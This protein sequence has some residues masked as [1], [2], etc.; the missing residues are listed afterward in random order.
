M[1]A[2]AAG[3]LGVVI[4]VPG[5]LAAQLHQWRASFGEPASGLVPPHV[6]ILTHG[7]AGDDD[8]AMTAVAAVA[9]RVEPF[10]VV[11]RGAG[12]FLPRSPVVYLRLTAGARECVELHEG[13][14][15]A[16]IGS[17]AVFPYH[18]HVTLAQG[19]DQ[20]ALDEALIRFAGFAATFPARALGVFRAG[21]TAWEQV[22]E[23]PLGG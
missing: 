5:P 17:A 12:S 4:T 18:P 7:L 22:G 19:V 14:L 11:L 21:E 16:G 15:A 8:P 13:I 6:T 20:Q 2:P 1:A 10:T 3:S 23:V 9:T